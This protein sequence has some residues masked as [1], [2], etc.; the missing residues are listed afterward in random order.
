M[1]GEEYGFDAYQE[2]RLAVA[3]AALREFDD[4]H[5]GGRRGYGPSG[6]DPYARPPPEYYSEKS[7]TG[8]YVECL[9]FNFIIT[10]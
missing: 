5:A 10:L 2:R 8:R 3:A 9:M 6:G 7:D 4:M 1:R